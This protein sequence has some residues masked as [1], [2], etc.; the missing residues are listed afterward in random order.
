MRIGRTI[1]PAASPIY[2]RDVINGLRGLICGTR[3]DD[4]FRREIKDHFGV[5]HCF[6]V[7][8]GRAA[9]T[10]ILKA[11][12]SIRPDR[13]EVLIPAFCCYSV[14][15]AIVRAGLKVRLCD[16]NPDT[17][18]FDFEQLETKIRESTGDVISPGET[19]RAPRLLAVLSVN[20]FGLAADVDRV[21]NL[22]KDSLAFIIEDSA[23]A[24]AAEVNKRK[25]G[26]R[27]DIGFF[28]LG[29]SKPISVVEG[30][31]IVTNRD[32]I[33]VQIESEMKKVPEYCLYE[34]LK[35]LL[36]AMVLM[37][38]QRPSLFWFPKALPFL[39]V[40]DTI[41]DPNFKIRKM[42]SVQAGLAKFWKSK[43]SAF[44]RARQDAAKQWKDALGL[45]AVLPF[46]SKNG[47]EPIYI[48]FPVRIRKSGLW[49]RILDKSEND[50]L[51]IMLTYPDAI[52]GVP[53]LREQFSSQ[54]FQTARNLAREILTVPVH[55]LLSIRDKEKIISF[56]SPLK[57]SIHT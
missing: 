10:L 9:L 21:R 24:M 46:S 53:A 14:P 2:L 52:N 38:F 17:L 48:R 1:P 19:S 43:L 47:Q 35:I 26:N 23:Q 57:A 31:I 25:L 50:G 34:R 16:I 4:R 12:H 51:G 32:D 6:L 3:E 54:D 30:G 36:Q 55:P 20:L 33:A 13:D 49:R 27:G 22:I 41:Y 8:S 15:S 7:S 5:R 29:R 56:I 44:E 18:D 40:G 39:R 11:L 28:S 45:T 37:L 42:S